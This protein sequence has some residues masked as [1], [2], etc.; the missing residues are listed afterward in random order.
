MNKEIN[1]IKKKIEQS[2][3]LIFD[4]DGVIADSVEVK[5]Q[6]FASLYEPYGEE[7]V[8][9]VLEHHKKNGGMSRFEKFKYYH[10]NFL[11]KDIGKESINQLSDD[12][13][14]NVFQKVVSSKEINAVSDFL[15]LHSLN[16]KIF[17]INSATPQ[18]EIEKIILARG[19]NKF[20]SS[21]FGSP[22]SKLENIAKILNKYNCN[23]DEVVFFGDSRNDLMAAIEADIE[24]VGV[25]S[26]IRKE[27]ENMK[28]NFNCMM[29]FQ[30]ILD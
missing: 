11:N 27:I 13:S 26:N 1:K 23:K 7:I 15:E 28:R 29:D 5:T 2:R 3:L 9:K 14:K 20:F 6:A 10:R 4:F 8:Q 19:L 17:V 22:S 25:G 21:V 24:F 30:K 18:A 16:E 12:F